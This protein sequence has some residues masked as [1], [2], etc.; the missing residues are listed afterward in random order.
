MDL[1][2][3]VSEE[4]KPIYEGA[5]GT[6]KGEALWFATNEDVIARLPELLREGDVIL[7]KASNTARL[8]QVADAIVGTDNQ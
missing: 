1:L 2:I 3:A 5:S 4:A 7:T 8:G 6:G